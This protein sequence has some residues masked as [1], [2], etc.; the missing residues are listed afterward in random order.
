M[1]IKIF[2]LIAIVLLIGSGTYMRSNFAYYNQS[3]M[4][5]NLNKIFQNK[6][7]LNQYYKNQLN[8]K[9][10]YEECKKCESHTNEEVQK[11]MLHYYWADMIFAL[12]YGMLFLI[13]ADR[14]RPRN[15]FIYRS[16]LFEIIIFIL[17]I[18]DV[19][20]NGIMICY[21][22]NM[23]EE[24]LRISWL[25]WLNGIK[26]LFFIYC[27][28]TLLIMQLPFLYNKFKEW[29]KTQETNPNS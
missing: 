15:G 8:F 5:D 17:V 26:T 6:E 10:K 24:N 16:Y 4:G 28:F 12:A 13:I 20:E 9:F 7:W 23:S 2:F 27:I 3:G 22:Q 29:M 21:F 18:C 25:H 19:S 1:N 14:I 11:M